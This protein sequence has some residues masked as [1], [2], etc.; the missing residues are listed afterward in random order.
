MTSY[1]NLLLQ[2]LK[3]LKNTSFDL[4]GIHL[5]F[6][7]RGNPDLGYN[8]VEWVWENGSLNF[9]A[10]GYF[11]RILFLNDSLLKWHTDNSEVLACFKMLI[12]MYCSTPRCIMIYLHH[13]PEVYR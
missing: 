5:V 3:I 11:N 1:L 13:F 4:N 2:L 12:S 6:D 7:S 10:V 8:M 9:M